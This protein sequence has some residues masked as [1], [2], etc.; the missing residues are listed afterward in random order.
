MRVDEMKSEFVDEM[1]VDDMT[2]D[3]VGFGIK[4]VD[5]VGVD[6]SRQSGNRRDG[7]VPRQY[8]Q[9]K[10]SRLSICNCKYI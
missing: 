1:R 5:E 2:V 6:S 10:N 4:S 7:R 8:V 9:K 3:E